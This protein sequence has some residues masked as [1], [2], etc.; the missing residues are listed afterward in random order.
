MQRFASD[1]DLPVSVLAQVDRGRIKVTGAIGSV[2]GSSLNRF[3]EEGPA[4]E[5]ARIGTEL[6]EKLLMSGETVIDLLEADFPDG[7][8]LSEAD[9]LPG[10]LDSELDAGMTVDIDGDLDAELN[11]LAEDELTDQT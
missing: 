6:A 4:A 11:D 5:A 1:Q 10:E 3:N 2:H 7:L 8:P 9:E